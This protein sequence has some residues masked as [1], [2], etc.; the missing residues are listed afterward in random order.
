MHTTA[1]PTAPLTLATLPALGAELDAG[2]FFGLTTDKAGAH[3][4]VVLLPDR[5]DKRLTWKQALA[6]AKKAGGELPTRPISALLYALAKDRIEA[7]WYWTSEAFDGS[8]AW[9]QGFEGGT[10]SG[11]P[12][13]YEGRAVAVRLIQLTT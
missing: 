13:S 2:H 7:D 8:Y 9:N 5:T 10:Q 3:H 11:N 12:K 4:A 1:T 6:W